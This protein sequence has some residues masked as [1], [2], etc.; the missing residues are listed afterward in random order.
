MRLGQTYIF[1]S[2]LPKKAATLPGYP[3]LLNKGWLILLSVFW[4]MKRLT[5]FLKKNKKLFGQADQP[6]GIDNFGWL[7]FFLRP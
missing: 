3:F 2:N 1:I 5:L 7:Y 6:L 4:M